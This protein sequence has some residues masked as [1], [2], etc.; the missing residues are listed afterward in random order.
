MV[1]RLD[2]ENHTLSAQRKCP[3]STAAL[4]TNKSS[5]N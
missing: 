2:H 5:T 1:K 4:D 3:Y